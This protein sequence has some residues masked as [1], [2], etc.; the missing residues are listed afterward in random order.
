MKSVITTVR[1][2]ILACLAAITS[3]ALM[4]QESAKQ[5]PSPKDVGKAPKK[6]RPNLAITNPKER[7]PLLARVVAESKNPLVRKHAALALGR[8][9]AAARGVLPDLR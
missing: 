2:L 7:A 8:M 3:S 6:A 4:G 5:P 9:G 1:L